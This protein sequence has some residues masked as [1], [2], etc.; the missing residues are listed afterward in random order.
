MPREDAMAVQGRVWTINPLLDERW[1][2]FVERHPKSSVFHTHGWLNALRTTYGYEPVAFTTSAPS[3]ELTNALLFCAV[4]SWL[5]HDRLVSLPFTDHCEPLVENIEQLRTLCAHLQTLRKAHRWKYAEMRTSGDL[6]GAEGGLKHCE[7]Y[8]WHRL[9]LRP[10]LDALSKG[11]HKSCTRRRI[12]HAERQGLRYEE[13]RNES[14]VRAFYQL[15][16]LSRLRKHLPPQPLEWF[17]TLVSCMGTDV[18]IRLAFKGDHPIAG[19]LTMSHGKTMYYKYGGSDSRFNH[20]G[21]TPM[22]FWRAIQ[23]AK[24]AGMEEFD[25]GRSD[26]DNRGLI[27]FKGRWGARGVS[28]IRWR[29]SADEISLSLERLKV[30]LA[31]TICT[32]VPRK[33]LVSVGRLM[34]RH[35]G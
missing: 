19:I 34:Y 7:V 33:M 17:Q 10:S 2:Q 32:F 16:V 22:L 28:L 21:A 14:L 35:V 1:P 25:L 29:I 13:G 9:D 4:R 31:K 8:E 20:L 11:F 5:T 30:R 18:C 27:R 26:L 3:E 24:F 23:S 6:F 15:I 12:A